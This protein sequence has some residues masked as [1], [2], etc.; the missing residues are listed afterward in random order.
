MKILSKSVKLIIN[1]TL[2][3]LNNNYIINQYMKINSWKNITI[4]YI[5]LFYILQINQLNAV[6]SIPIKPKSSVKITH[7]KPVT[8]PVKKQNNT[9]YLANYKIKHTQPQPILA[10]GKEKPLPIKT[11]HLKDDDLVAMA[12]DAKTGKILFSKKAHERCHPA[13][14]TKLMT[15]YILFDY[16]DRNKLTLNDKIVFSRYASSKPRSKLDV[17]AGDAITVRQAISAL[18]VLSANDVAVAVGENIAGSEGKFVQLMNKKAKEL[19]LSN[20]QFYNPSGLFHPQQRSTA[21][22]MIRLAVSLK[23][24]FPQYYKYFSETSFNF[25]GRTISGHNKITKNYPGAEGLK[26]GYISQSGF[27][28]V[29]SASK[30][31]KT[32]FA[33]VLGGKTSQERDIFM[34]KLLDAS[35]SKLEKNRFY[36]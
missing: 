4:F 29:S 36:S 1:Q 16:L 25:R 24:N 11:T 35:F 13:S 3:T 2:I 9:A 7:K 18:I 27:N 14:L 21:A 26:T 22:D 23:H 33:A 19:K 10:K 30:D 32:V 17:P 34:F 31:K 5:I 6:E 12:I 28:I 20:T 15:L 8:A